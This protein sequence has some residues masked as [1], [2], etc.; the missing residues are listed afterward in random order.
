MTNLKIGI[1]HGVD[2][3]LATGK[4]YGST[5]YSNDLTYLIIKNEVLQYDTISPFGIKFFLK[6]GINSGYISTSSMIFKEGY[7]INFEDTTL[8]AHPKCK[9][10]KMNIDSIEKIVIRG[11][12]R[13]K[14]K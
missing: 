12:R 13:N 2:I 14:K 11:I 4:N 6:S 8:K 1:S 10:C 9:T 3:D 5:R 7:F